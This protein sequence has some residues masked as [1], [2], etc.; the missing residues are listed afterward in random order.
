MQRGLL[1]RT[2]S[3]R[4]GGIRLTEDENTAIVECIE[5]TTAVN[6]GVAF[7]AV[8]I[9]SVARGTSAHNSDIDV[10]FVAAQ[11]LRLPRRSGRMHVQF[12]LT[13]DFLYRLR[14]GDDFASW[15][16]R[17]GLPITDPGIWSSITA[18]PEAAQWPG[19]KRKLPHATRRLFLAS[20]LLR[21]GDVTAATEEALYAATHTARAILLRTGVFPL[22]S[23][24]NR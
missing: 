17:L 4:S 24:R 20:Q 15:C 11:E 16:V 22:S 9:G 14:I 6:P 18:A 12:F 7:A 2:H 19:W 5:T 23:A 1:P 21:A 3:G 13:K 8:L 10:V